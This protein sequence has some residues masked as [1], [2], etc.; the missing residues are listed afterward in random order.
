MSQLIN[1]LNKIGNSFRLF[2]PNIVRI[3]LGIF[4]FYKGIFFV[5]YAD[6]LTELISPLDMGL[7]EMAI[8][9]YVTLA[10][11]A[12]GI[13]IIIGLLT[14][15][16]VIAQIPILIGAIIFNSISGDL[17]QLVLSVVVL[18]FLSFYA[19]VGSGKWSADYKMQLHF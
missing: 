9:H 11:I 17:N 8:Y 18:L 19:V 4:I 10:H 16:S 7:T 15:I 12:G 13:F 5:Q 6:N 1:K 2:E 3:L 14:R